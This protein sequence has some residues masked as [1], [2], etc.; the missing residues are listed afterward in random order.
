VREQIDRHLRNHTKFAEE[1]PKLL[2]TQ[3][4]RGDF[5]GALINKEGSSRFHRAYKRFQ[6]RYTEGDEQGQPFVLDRLVTAVL[7]RLE[8]VSV[9]LEA[10]DSPHRL[11][12]SL[13]SK[14]MELTAADLIRNHVF[15][16]LASDAA[17][18]EA[19]YDE[20]WRP[21]EQELGKHFTGFFWRFLMMDGSLLPLGLIFK[22][23]RDKFR[24]TD[25]ADLED[26]LHGLRDHAAAYRCI[27]APAVAEDDPG[28]RERLE[29]INR[30][31]L[32]T[33]FP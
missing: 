12:E 30:W 17:R 15:M 2:P 27:V 28:I 7:S 8:L 19:V 4:D 24:S 26:F 32:D 1:R 33:A 10:N 6:K 31:E 5:D 11:F 25:D 29:R 21:M 3:D 22:T 14:G 20:L 13:N 9:R 16:R 18:Q 23:F